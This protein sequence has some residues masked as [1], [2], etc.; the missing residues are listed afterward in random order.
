MHSGD[1]ATI[2]NMIGLF[3]IING[4]LIQMI[5]VSRV[6][7]GLGVRGQ[8]P[9]ALAYVNRASRTPLVATA[10]VTVIVLTLALIGRLASLAEATSLI[11]L[12][13]FALVNLSLLRIKVREPLA[14]GCWTFPSWVPVI[15]FLLSVMFVVSAGIDLLGS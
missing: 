4:V 1:D 11:M 13:V 2:I 12:I 10:L 9:N 6:I 14:A 15:G 5:M 3:A 8:L 7:Y